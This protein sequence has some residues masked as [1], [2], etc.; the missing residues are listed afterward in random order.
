MRC[1]I[2]QTLSRIQKLQ[3]SQKREFYHTLL[4]ISLVW[5][6]AFGMLGYVCWSNRAA[7]QGNTYIVY[8][9][10]ETVSLDRK[11]HDA[12]DIQF[13]SEQSTFYVT[14]RNYGSQNVSFVMQN[15]SQEDCLLLTVLNDTD[16]RVVAINGHSKEYLSIQE[17]NHWHQRNMISGIA[18]TIMLAVFFTLLFGLGILK[19]IR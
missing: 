9:P 17:Y 10:G 19:Y 12:P 8:A 11:V 13:I 6:I 3:K 7:S 5:G 4:K 15:M 16:G 14:W 2:F 18:A 1:T